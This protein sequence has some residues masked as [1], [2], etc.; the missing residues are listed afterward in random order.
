MPVIKG[1]QP[2]CGHE[3]PDQPVPGQVDTLT[4]YTPKHRKRHA[5]AVLVEAIQKPLTLRA[6]HAG[7]L[8][9]LGNMRGQ[10]GKGFADLIEIGEA[11]EKRQIVARPFAVLA[12]YQLS[13]W[14]QRPFTVRLS[15]ADVRGKTQR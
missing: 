1:W 12:G 2:K 4:E 13:D 14:R 11:A 10:T 6:G 7:A 9:S 3:G 8:A 15:G 5:L